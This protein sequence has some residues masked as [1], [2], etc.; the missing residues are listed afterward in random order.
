MKSVIDNSV[1]DRLVREGYFE[2]L[3][4]AGIKAEI[5]RKTALAVR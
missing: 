1:V 5:N 4:G 2:K 3:F